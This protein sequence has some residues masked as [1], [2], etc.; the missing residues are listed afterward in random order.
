[1]ADIKFGKYAFQGP[2]DGA[3]FLFQKKGVF[4]ILCRDIRE[5][6]K[7]YIVDI[8]ESDDVRTAAMNHPR[9]VEWVKNC[10]GVGTLALGVMYTELMEKEER[11]KVVNYI[12]G[13]FETPCG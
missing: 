8:D 2:Y 1:M 12:R 10:H 6:G 3:R 5:Q 11:K 13:L 9:Q 4:V 7:F